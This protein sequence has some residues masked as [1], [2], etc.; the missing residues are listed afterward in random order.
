MI[1]TASEA[2]FACF[3]LPPSGDAPG[4]SSRMHT[5]FTKSGPKIEIRCVKK[6][7]EAVSPSSFG[8]SDGEPCSTMGR[9]GNGRIDKYVEVWLCRYSSLSKDTRRRVNCAHRFAEV[10]SSHIYCASVKLKPG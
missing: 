3:F 2:L 7:G 5:G 8:S 6:L 1:E 4:S 10:L 9:Y